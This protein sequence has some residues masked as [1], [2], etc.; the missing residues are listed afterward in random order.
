MERWGK[1][2]QLIYSRKYVSTANNFDHLKKKRWISLQTY[3][4]KEAHEWGF[5]SPQETFHVILWVEWC[6]YAPNKRH[7]YVF[8]RDILLHNCQ[9]WIKR[10]SQPFSLGAIFPQKREINLTRKR[11]SRAFFTEGYSVKCCAL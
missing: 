7:F 2:L 1:L 9:I 11:I 4:T 5:W 8:T 3:P 6:P 10:L